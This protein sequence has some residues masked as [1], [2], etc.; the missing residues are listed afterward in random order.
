MNIDMKKILSTILLGLPFIA[1]AQMFNF[2]FKTNNQQFIEDAIK[3]SIV[4]VEQKYALSDSISGDEFGRNELDYFNFVDYIGFETEK[5]LITYPEIQKPWEND[6]PFSQYK[7][8]Y[9]PILK[10]TE[11]YKLNADDKAASTLPE[12]FAS[13]LENLKGLV[14]NRDSLNVIKGLQI[15]SIAG[16]KDGWAVWITR[17]GNSEKIDSVS[18]TC[19]KQQIDIPTDGSFISASLP[20]V[21]NEVLGGIYVTPKVTAP[22][23]ITFYLNGVYT[24]IDDS[25]LL[26]FPFITDMDDTQQKVEI[27][28][29]TP[30]EAPNQLPRKPKFGK[31]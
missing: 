3:G 31:K 12:D 22:G 28:R 21:E 29:L 24:C 5:G 10:V 30:I 16:V 14:I 23:Q 27:E 25:W 17:K 20:E 15:D 6:K 2:G 26:I 18:F 4:C 13:S 1:S 19:I 8:K 9:K 7:G 11:L